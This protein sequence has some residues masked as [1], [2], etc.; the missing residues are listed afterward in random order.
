MK[1]KYGTMVAKLDAYSQT[2]GHDRTLRKA[3][4]Q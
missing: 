4:R 3:V 1:Q 2:A